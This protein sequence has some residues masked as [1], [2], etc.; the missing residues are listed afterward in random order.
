MAS[1]TRLQR[2]VD[3]SVDGINVPTW[4]SALRCRRHLIG[5]EQFA[6]ADWRGRPLAHH[7]RRRGEA[8]SK[9]E[10]RRLRDRRHEADACERIDKQGDGREPKQKLAELPWVA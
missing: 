7:D 10:H 2:S 4:R 5:A 3:L 6:L 1:K 9:K 8:N